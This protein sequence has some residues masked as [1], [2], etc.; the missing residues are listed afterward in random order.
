VAG[1]EGGRGGGQAVRVKN[2]QAEAEGTRGRKIYTCDGGTEHLFIESPR[3][4][5]E[6]EEGKIAFLWNDGRC[7]PTNVPC[8]ARLPSIH[9]D[10]PTLH[11]IASRAVN[12]IL[13]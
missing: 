11:P 9:L 8:S 1:E 3:A 13:I 5:E 10:A 7:V 4:E 2:S 12:H 6:E